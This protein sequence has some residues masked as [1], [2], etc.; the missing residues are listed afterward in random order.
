MN[1]PSRSSQR[2]YL[3]SSNLQLPI[4]C[5]EI[6]WV[7]YRS[8]KQF[9]IANTCFKKKVELLVQTFFWSVLQL[10][11]MKYPPHPGGMERGGGQLPLLWKVGE[12]QINVFAPPLFWQKFKKKLNFQHGSKTI[13][14]TWPSGRN[15]LFCLTVLKTCTTPHTHFLISA[16]SCSPFPVHS[17]TCPSYCPFQYYHPAIVLS[18][19]WPLGQQCINIV[20]SALS[21]SPDISWLTNGRTVN[22]EGA[23]AVHYYHVD[24]I[25]TLLL[26]GYASPTPDLQKHEQITPNQ[27]KVKEMAAPALFT[28]FQNDTFEL[29]IYISYAYHWGTFMCIYQF[30]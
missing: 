3:E 7:H 15:L 11:N 29:H 22:M 26:H 24:H 8:R 21:V 28:S 25:Q 4:A 6:K 27:L 16:K 5:K 13:L 2:R 30:I 10:W 18:M 23:K 20:V 12:G 19:I 14:S 9:V 17:Q 1:N